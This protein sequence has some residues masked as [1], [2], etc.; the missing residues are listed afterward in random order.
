[1]QTRPALISPGEPFDIYYF[2]RN[3]TD[4]ATYYVQAVV[5]DVRTGEVLFTAPLTGMASNPHLF[6]AIAQ[7]PADSSGIGRNILAVAS[8]YL[9]AAFTSKSTDYEEQE[10]AF[11]VKA[12]LGF[13][14]GG[15][16]DFTG[17][18]DGIEERIAKTLKKALQS[19]E[20]EEPAPTDLSG[21]FGALGA[22]QREINRIPKDCYDDTELKAHVSGVKDAVANIPQPEKVN[23]GPIQTHLARIA[24]LVGGLQRELS[25]ASTSIGVRQQMVLDRM[26]KQIVDQAS[27][28]LRELYEKQDLSIP[29]S[30]LIRGDKPAAPKK[31]DLSHL[32]NS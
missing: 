8:V 25:G 10:Q 17:L 22:I 20:R 18:A 14:T 2:L 15:A 19:I 16:I 28:A 1:M 13:P 3:P 12:S 30:A 9:D 23:L 31:P 27:A 21:V 4:T 6:A 29:L 11:L 26:S 5:Y 24:E 32:M 7:A